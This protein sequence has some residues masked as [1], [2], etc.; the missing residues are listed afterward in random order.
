MRFGGDDHRGGAGVAGGDPGEVHEARRLP[1]LAPLVP[2]IPLLL[3][4]LLRRWWASRIDEEAL[5]HKNVEVRSGGGGNRK[6]FGIVLAAFCCSL[7]ERRGLDVVVIHRES[8]G[9]VCRHFYLV[10]CAS[11][12][13]PNI[14]RAA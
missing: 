8:A 3:L 2:W 7:N 10:Q 13:P 5:R 9:E 1:R 11:T 12:T 4:L 14:R 6:Y